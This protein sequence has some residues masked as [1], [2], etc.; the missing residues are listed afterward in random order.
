MQLPR[1]G[2][3]DFHQ[4]VIPPHIIPAIREL[5]VSIRSAGSIGS[6]LTGAG[7]G[8]CSISL[9]RRQDLVPFVTAVIESYYKAHPQRLAQLQ[10]M[11]PVTSSDIFHSSSTGELSIAHPW[12]EVVFVCDPALGASIVDE[13]F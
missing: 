6:R 11:G 13:Q 7:W 10:Q 8:G 5:T 2:R 12:S 4:Q 3:L 1:V 9:I